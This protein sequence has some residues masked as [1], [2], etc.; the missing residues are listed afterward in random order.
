[1]KR[2]R[3]V[4]LL[5]AAVAMGAWASPM[6]Q[7]QPGRSE[8]DARRG[9]QED[10]DPLAAE[11]ARWSHYLRDNPSKDE[12]WVDLKTSTLPAVEKTEEALKDG[13]RYL[14]LQRL[15]VARAN[16]AAQVYVDETPEA[17][18][19]DLAAFEAEWKRLGT[20]LA[21]D[22]KAPSAG[23]LAGVTP[24]AVR[25][26][27]EASVPQVRT[28]YD[29]SIDYSRNTMADAGYFYLGDARAQ[30]DF[31]AFCRSLS[32]PVPNGLAAPA[33][34]SLAGEIDAL[35]GELLALYRPPASI[36]RH[37]DFIAASATL[38]EARELDGW[39]LRDGALLRYLQAAQKIAALRPPSSLE[40]AALAERLAAIGERLDASGR[41][42]S[43]GRI[44]LEAAQGDVAHLEAGKKPEAAAAA[45]ADVLPR[46]FA[47]LEPAKPAPAKPP[48]A[49]TVTLV[50]WPY[51]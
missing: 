22:L 30:K 13:H 24:A 5:L 39:G 10:S 42:D 50:R 6:R 17:Q 34:R 15:A 46:Y 2:L 41:D 12:D 21:A 3:L 14:A 44:F 23:A 31:V 16:L 51:T 7:A 9:P 25:A 26:V 36:D 32:R 29:A 47:A 11:I 28:Y 49:V 4:A 40:G 8:G 33:L 48:A 43:I 27:G 35:E 19:Q 45:A 1:M 20:A 38:K 18:R 37:K